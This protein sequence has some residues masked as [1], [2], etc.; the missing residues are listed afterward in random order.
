MT[1]TAARIWRADAVLA[2]IRPLR[3][4]DGVAIR[5][6]RLTGAQPAGLELA[7]QFGSMTLTT[8]EVY[9]HAA[10]LGR[11]PAHRRPQ[12]RSAIA[13][14]RREHIAEDALAVDADEDARPPGHVTAHEGE[15]FG[16]VERTPERDAAERPPFGGDD[17][18]TD[19]GDEVLGAMPM[20][21]QVGDR[22][23]E[24]PVRGPRRCRGRP[25]VAMPCFDSS[26]ISQRIPDG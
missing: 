11:D 16:A 22:H 6:D 21:D 1:P 15:V 23:D 19:P 25:A 7:A 3:I 18:I 12:L 26:T 20:L 9:D 13:G 10:V 24:Q 4:A 2:G 14:V 8:V 17:G 5:L